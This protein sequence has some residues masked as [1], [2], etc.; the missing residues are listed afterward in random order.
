MEEGLLLPNPK[1]QKNCSLFI[2]LFL[3]L[4]NSFAISWELFSS[5][6]N[7]FNVLVTHSI[8]CAFWINYDI[9]KRFL[10]HMCQKIDNFG[11]ELILR[12][13]L[14]SI[15][16]KGAPIR[17]FTVFEF[18]YIIQILSWL[19]YIFWMEVLWMFPKML[20]PEKRTKE[21][22]MMLL[23][24]P[25][26][27]PHSNRKS[28]SILDRQNMH[29]H[30]FKKRQTKSFGIFLQIIRD[31]QEFT[32]G[33][34]NTQLQNLLRL[35]RFAASFWILAIIANFS[36]YCNWFEIRKWLIEF[37]AVMSSPRRASLRVCR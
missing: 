16:P 32:I 25:G 11:R 24:N 17:D 5:I 27:I 8:S 6:S 4:I 21:F 36:G 15:D 23:L 29:I 20:M 3:K 2:I 28:F 37:V 18:I 12:E 33:F 22:L 7:L 14:F 26:T 31:I 34:S 19:R 10:T 1:F 35:S 13:V 30:I 9:A